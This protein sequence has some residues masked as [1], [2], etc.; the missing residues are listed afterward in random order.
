MAR[1]ITIRPGEDIVKCYNCGTLIVYDPM[2]DITRTGGFD[3]FAPVR[4]VIM[5]PV[6]HRDV[7]V[8]RTGL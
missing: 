4:N 5:C 3:N 1:A 2:T 7:D 6:C 8:Y